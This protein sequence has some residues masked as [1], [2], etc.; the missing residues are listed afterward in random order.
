[1]VDIRYSEEFANDNIFI[2]DRSYSTFL[3]AIPPDFD[4]QLF[5][6]I[7]E[8]SQ[9]SAYQLEF[10]KIQLIVNSC[11]TSPISSFMSYGYE[12]LFVARLLSDLNLIL[13]GMYN[14]NSQHVVFFNLL[15]IELEEKITN[16]IQE[17]VN[18]EDR[19][20]IPTEK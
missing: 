11:K 2:T 5:I 12:G 13:Y 16:S 1:M 17:I 15:A 9:M 6:S 20:Y 10:R 4:L 18:L 3:V 8:Q 19:Y 7:R 14:A